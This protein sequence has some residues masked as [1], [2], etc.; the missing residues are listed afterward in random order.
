MDAYAVLGDRHRPDRRAPGAASLS[1]GGSTGRPGRRTCCWSRPRSGCWRAGTTTP[2]GWSSEARDADPQGEAGFFHLVFSSAVAMQTGRG[3]AELTND[4]A[5]VVDDL[6]YLA[7]GWFCAMLKA[8]GRREEAELLWRALAPHVRRFPDRAPEWVIAA[9]GHAEVCAWLGGRR[10][11]AGDLRPARAVLRAARHR[12]R[13]DAV[14]RPG[15]PRP[16]PAGRD[17]RRPRPRS[18]APAAPRCARARPC[19]RLRARRSS[20]PSS[21]R[22]VTPRRQPERAPWPPPRGWRRCWPGWRARGTTARSRPGVRDRGPRCRRPEQ[23][24]DSRSADALGAHRR[25]PRQP[26]AAQARP[27]LARRHRVLARP[28]VRWLRCE[29]VHGRASNR[30]PEEVVSRLVAGAPH[31]STTDGWPSLQ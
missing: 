9:V 10:D 1:C 6:P 16:R 14:R 27:H 26:R 31:T 12:P 8:G 20:S 19:T 30:R 3:L 18:P 22:S 2:S 11:G 13:R 28:Q 5:G 4:G 25:E 15:R 7:G 29:A 21:V 23:R 17:V 24:R